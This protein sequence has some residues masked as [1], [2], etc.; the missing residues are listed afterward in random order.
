MVVPP[1]VVVVGVGVG[2]LVSA[3]PVEVV[4]PMA[5]EVLE[6]VPVVVPCVTDVN[7]PEEVLDVLP[8]VVVPVV[9]AGTEETHS[10]MSWLR[11][12]PFQGSLVE[13]VSSGASDRC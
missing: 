5:G 8:P 3:L 10:S 2:V 12:G 11:A 7:V 13:T 1:V 6:E 4:V 9:P